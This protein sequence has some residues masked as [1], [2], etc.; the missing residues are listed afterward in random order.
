MT[1]AFGAPGTQGAPQT[2][3]ARGP[4]AVVPGAAILSDARPAATAAR[5]DFTCL[6][7]A[8]QPARLISA[9]R[10]AAPIVQL[11]LTSLSRAADLAEVRTVFAARAP[12]RVPRGSIST[13]RV[14]QRPTQHAQLAPHRVPLDSI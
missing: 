1:T 12:P 8:L 10:N 5:V 9:A 4:N 2:S 7:A 14:R 6:E 13:V 11:V 3:T